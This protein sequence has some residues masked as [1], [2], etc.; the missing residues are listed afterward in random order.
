MISQRSGNTIISEE[1]DDME[2]VEVKDKEKEQRKQEEKKK[3]AKE[4]EQYVKQF[5][6]SPKY[7]SNCLKA[8]I[9][10]GLIC[11][12]AFYVQGLFMD[13]G[14]NEKD[15]GTLITVI[16]VCS[17]QLLTGLGVYDTIGK[18]AGAGSIIPIT[19]FANSMVAPAIEYKKEGIVLGVGAKLFSL[20][21][22]VLVCGISASVIIG[23][24]YYFI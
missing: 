10:G 15:A 20:A 18:F 23:I 4:Y 19:G 7:F 9:V 1:N 6:P 5:T 13:R 12:A 22:P 2:G 3:Q 16:L 8:F 21:G 17:A 24:V 11:V 14:M